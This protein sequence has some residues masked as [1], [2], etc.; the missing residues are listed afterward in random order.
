MRASEASKGLPAAPGRPCAP[1]GLECGQGVRT[2]YWVQNE[3]V[4]KYDEEEYE[5]FKE[6]CDGLEPLVVEERGD[7]F[8]HF[9][10]LIYAIPHPTRRHGVEIWVE[11]RW[12]PAFGYSWSETKIKRIEVY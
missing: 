12:V 1:Q 4:L 9:V 6:L 5:W 11:R 8:G 2:I 7:E 10:T 3:E